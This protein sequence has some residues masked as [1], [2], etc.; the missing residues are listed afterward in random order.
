MLSEGVNKAVQCR[1]LHIDEDDSFG[2]LVF[3]NAASPNGM[4]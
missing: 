4:T 2:L 1:T 3:E